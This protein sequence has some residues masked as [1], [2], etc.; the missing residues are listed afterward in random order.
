MQVTASNIHVT[1]SLYVYTL[2]EHDL[3]FIEHDLIFKI[4]NFS[5]YL[6]IQFF[7]NLINRNAT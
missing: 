7:R 3:I 6:D 5:K 4:V 1:N 2:I